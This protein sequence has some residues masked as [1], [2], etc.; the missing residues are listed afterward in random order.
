MIAL[1]LVVAAGIP[2]VVLVLAVVLPE[3]GERPCERDKHDGNDCQ[4]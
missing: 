1:G 4:T 3:P 2:L